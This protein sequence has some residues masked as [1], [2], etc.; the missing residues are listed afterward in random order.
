MKIIPHPPL[1][2]ILTQV[3]AS[4]T[5]ALAQ[6][7]ATQEQETNKKTI[8]LK[9][10]KELAGQLT[11]RQLDEYKLFITNE[12]KEIC[13]SIIESKETQELCAAALE[14]TAALIELFEQPH[15]VNIGFLDKAMFSMQITIPTPQR[16]EMPIGDV[17]IIL[18]FNNGGCTSIPYDWL[19]RKTQSLI[20]YTEEQSYDK[21]CA[22]LDTY[23]ELLSQLGSVNTI[24]CIH[25]ENVELSLSY[26]IQDIISVPQ[27]G[28]YTMHMVRGRIDISQT[29]EI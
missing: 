23:D 19:R 16:K 2:D 7:K 14:Q 28:D 8:Y 29:Q 21:L 1:M 27:D 17:P 25:R 9:E 24:V 13:Q 15:T 5:R 10:C 12:C 20:D 4:L 18:Q 11:R 26:P 6:A 22:V 3:Q